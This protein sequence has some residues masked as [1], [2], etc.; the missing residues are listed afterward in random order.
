MSLATKP[1]VTA[2]ALAER[3]RLAVVWRRF[4][5]SKSA[6]IGL[7]V[8][9]L[10]LLTAL[11]APYLVPH[12]PEAADFALAL[13][14]PS[15]AHWLGTD[16]L[17]RDLLSRLLMGAR[18]SGLI[19]VVSVSIGLLIGVPIGLVAGYYGGWLDLI[20]SR[21]IEMLLAF[22]SILLAIFM[23]AF[24]GPGLSQT[25][26]SGLIPG[27]LMAAMISV[28]I[29][30]VPTY[31]RL[32]RGSTLMVREDDYVTAARAAGAR[33]LRILFKHVLPNVAAPILVQSSLQIAGAILSAAALG[34]LGMGAPPN[35]PEWGT[36]LQ[37]ARSYVF[38]SPHMMAFPG[39]AIALV[40]LGFNLLGDGLRDALDPRMKD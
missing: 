17:G 23:V 26:F 22:P 32:V 34:F 11:L 40:V 15:G 10:F 20:I 2:Q 27:Q 35:I 21:C 33:D 24:L 28:G 30:S 4:R 29:V 16:E 13:Q 5:R 37:K 18:I 12:N 6:V 38:S 3:G 8:V 1:A 39:L 14:G 19:G 7:G 9:T 36:M 25:A 31:A